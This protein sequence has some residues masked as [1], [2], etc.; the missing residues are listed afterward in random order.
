M[1]F[2]ALLPAAGFSRRMGTE[3]L[4]LLIDGQP[5]LTRLIQTF[6]GAGVEKVLVVLGPATAD[7]ADAVQAAGACVFCLP[8]ATQEMQETVQRG[9]AWIN[10]HWQPLATDAFFLSPADH[11]AITAR[12]VLQL[13]DW[14]DQHPHSLAFKPTFQGKRGHP[15]LCRWQL[16]AAILAAAT[17]TG[18]NSILARYRESTVTREVES[19][20]ILADMDTPADYD[21]IKRLL[22]VTSCKR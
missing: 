2:F 11:P 6:R 3:K 17:G 13:K 22:S 9:L 21:Q 5:V 12:V 15:V 16:S 14:L 10:T 4:R 8:E 20:G 19:P 7:L 18:L 1:T